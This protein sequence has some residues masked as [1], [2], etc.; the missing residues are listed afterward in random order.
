M[1]KT[2]LRR[3]DLVFSYVL[4]VV[5]IYSMIEAVSIF[6][7]PMG[8]DFD[9]V[10]GDTIKAA[11]T[12]W[13]KSPGLMPFLL[14]IVIFFL[15][16]VLRDIAIKDGAKFDF[17]TKSHFGYFL[18]L[19]ETWVAVTIIVIFCA[20]VF[21][22]IPQCRAHLNFF[23]KFQGF[24]FMIATFVFLAT[25][26]IIFNKRTWKAVGMSLLVAALAS[27]AITY[28]FG[29]LAMIPLP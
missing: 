18:K 11:I 28:G 4:M 23:P 29:M 27:G 24:P 10:K 25:Q 20:Y 22:L 8:M 9:R 3:A 7:N 1:K 14:G 26:M 2:T 12:G 6:I 16:M 15:A 5:A 19:R 13:Y 21:I 17:L